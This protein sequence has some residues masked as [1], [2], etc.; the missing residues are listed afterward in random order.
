MRRVVTSTVLAC[1]LTTGCASF[2]PYV[3]T[4]CEVPPIPPDLLA[5][6][7]CPPLPPLKDGQLG[8]IY[9]QMVED[10]QTYYECRSAR[11]QLIAVAKYRDQVCN[12]FRSQGQSDKK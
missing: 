7:A 12:Q 10:A 1:F 9:N 3:V 11:K 2:R 6:E 5:E 4:T 8:T